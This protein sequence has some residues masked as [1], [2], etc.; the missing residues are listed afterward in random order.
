MHESIKEIM[1]SNTQHWVLNKRLADKLANFVKAFINANE[2]HV[3]FFGSNLTGVHVVR[4]TTKDRM[5]LVDDILDIDDLTIQ[6]QVKSLPHI[7]DTWVRGTDGLNLALLYLV[8]LLEVD[9]KLSSKMRYDMQVNALLILQYKFLSSTLTAYFKYPVSS[10][11][12]LSVYQSL[13]G[14]YLIKKHGTWQALLL[15]RCHAILVKEDTHRKTIKMF[16]PDDKVQYMITDIQGRLKALIIN[17][18]SVTMDVKSRE[19]AIGTSSTMIE[20]D[21]ELTVRDIT[22]KQTDYLNYIR[23]VAKDQRDFVK[24]DLVEVI[25]ATITTLPKKLFVDALFGFSKACASNN[26]DAKVLIEEVVIYSFKYFAE[27]KDIIS[28]TRDYGKLIK[29]MK[30]LYT[31][32]K[33]S[34]PSVLKSR[35]LADKI[36]KKSVKTTNEVTTSALRVGLILYILLRT[37]TR[38]HFA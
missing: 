29:T 31:A 13:S 9:T 2:D 17:I 8:H 36:N 7:G 35:K 27:N 21:G 10:A 12:A 19:D 38:D 5:T 16:D 26:N 6:E 18:Y 14:K 25:D 1:A 32:G 3:G 23:T 30:D 34:T 22:R 24:M 15:A 4:F 20:L 37:L 33:S 28:D 11:V